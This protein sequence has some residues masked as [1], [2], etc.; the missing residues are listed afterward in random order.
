[1]VILNEFRKIE[2]SI[3]KRPAAPALAKKTPH[4]PKPTGNKHQ[5]TTKKCRFNLHLSLPDLLYAEM[6]ME[7][8]PNARKR[9]VLRRTY[10]CGY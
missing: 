2:P 5:Y 8:L 4:I 10:A 3:Q 9:C 7:E 1:M 6:R